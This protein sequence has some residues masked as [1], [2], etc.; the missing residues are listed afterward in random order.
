MA[1]M[2]ARRWRSGGTHTPIR[3]VVFALVAASTTFPRAPYPRGLTVRPWDLRL[4]LLRRMAQVGQFGH[5]CGDLLEFEVSK[6][7]LRRHDA[8]VS[9]DLGERNDI[10]AVPEETNGKRVTERVR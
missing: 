10:P 5:A 8:C 2:R 7:A 1:A 3:I 4:A 9:E 6:V